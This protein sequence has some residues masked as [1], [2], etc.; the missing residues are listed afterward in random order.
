MVGLSLLKESHRYST[1]AG[2][3]ASSDLVVGTTDLSTGR[4]TAYLRHS[5]SPEWLGD[6]LR[7]IDGRVSV[8]F[9][10]EDNGLGRDELA[11]C[12]LLVHIPS[13]RDA[14]TLN[15]SHAV[16]VVLYAVHRAR[17]GEDSDS[18]PAPERVELHGVEKELVLARIEALAR[19]SRYPAHKRKGLMLLFRR[20]LGRAAPAEAELRM[21]LGFL[22]SLSRND[23]KKHGPT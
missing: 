22:K 8:V 21:L 17:G 2:A 11:R 9:G 5:V 18:T 1:L 19:V 14:P 12:D 3:V 20:L 15:L 16:A 23:R 4:S 13:R 10:P 6:L 7:T